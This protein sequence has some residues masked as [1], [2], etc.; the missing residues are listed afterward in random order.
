MLEDSAGAT[1]LARPANRPR[2]LSAARA[3]ALRPILPLRCPPQSSSPTRPPDDRCLRGR[4]RLTVDADRRRAPA[5]LER[6]GTGRTDAGAGRGAVVIVVPRGEVHVERLEGGGRR[7]AESRR[8][9]R[10][11]DEP[12]GGT[13]GRHG[14]GGNERKEGNYDDERRGSGGDGGRIGCLPD[15]GGGERL[16][17]R[18]NS[19]IPAKSCSPTERARRLLVEQVVIYLV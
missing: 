5:K 2:R 9:N 15:A 7:P 19:S 11:G 16:A 6:K 8:R 18:R 17:G 13:K 12:G 4:R 14:W 10:R 3:R 1:F